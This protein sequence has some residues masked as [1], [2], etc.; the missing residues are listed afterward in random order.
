M[1]IILDNNTYKYE[2]EAIVDP[3]LLSVINNYNMVFDKFVEKGI[4]INSIEKEQEN[5]KIR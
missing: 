5:S 4:F 3:K 1:T 2:T